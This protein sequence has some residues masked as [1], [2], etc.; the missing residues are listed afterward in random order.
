MLTLSLSRKRRCCPIPMHEYAWDTQI[1]GCI[2]KRRCG[3]LS[4]LLTRCLI[5]DKVACSHAAVAPTGTSHA[6]SALTHVHFMIRVKVEEGQCSSIDHRYT[7]SSP[8][9]LI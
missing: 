7:P 1:N 3:G 2:Q 8:H 6:P 9:T 4:F 5:H